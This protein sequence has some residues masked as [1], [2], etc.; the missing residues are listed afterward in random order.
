M[1]GFGCSVWVRSLWFLSFGAGFGSSRGVLCCSR[2]GSW[3]RSWVVF[4]FLRVLVLG[5]LSLCSGALPWAVASLLFSLS[6]GFWDVS[7]WP[8]GFAFFREPGWLCLGTRSTSKGESAAQI[9]G[10]LGNSSLKAL[11][12][13]NAVVE[14]TEEREAGQER[15]EK[16]LVTKR[17]WFQ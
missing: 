6:F 14:R 11:T 15:T 1:C 8:L 5:S 7:S 10:T 9:F 12:F 4:L 13:A 2:S 17:E 16:E 3:R